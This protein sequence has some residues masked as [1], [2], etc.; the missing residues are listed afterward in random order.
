MTGADGQA[1]RGDVR[2]RWLACGEQD[3]P[4]GTAWLAERERARAA[5]LRFAKR[6]SEYLLRRWAGKRAVAAATGLDDAPGDLARVEVAH[7]PGGAPYVLVDG[8]AAAL[9]ISLTDRAGWAVCLL[10]RA[11]ARVGCDLE[12]VEPRS[13]GFVR[14]F[15]TPAERALVEA[16][17]RRGQDAAGADAARVGR[18]TAANLLWSAKESALKVLG[19]GLRR[20]TRSVEVTVPDPAP[21]GGTWARL[22]VRTAEGRAFPGWWTRCGAFLLT[23]AAEE[24]VL[25]PAALGGSADLGRAVPVHSWVAH[26]LSV[27][28]PAP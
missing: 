21:A 6:R 16:M 9:N 24:R 25:A 8:R 26:P 28:R 3:L 17:T 20:D 22:L 7:E 18:D 23:V 11:G 10:T 1:S 12:L 15:L 14:D 27:D 19:T 2:V 4:D 13:D 5:G